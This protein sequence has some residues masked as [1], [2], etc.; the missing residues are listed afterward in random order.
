MRD[1]QVAIAGYGDSFADEENVKT[2]MELA[3]Q[4]AVAA[5]E[6]A[7]I[8]LADVDA[9]LT[10][11]PPLA[12]RAP[13]GPRRTPV[14]IQWNNVVASY[15]NI[16]T[17]HSTGVTTHGAGTIAMLKHAQAAIEADYVDTVLCVQSDAAPLFVDAFGDIPEG[18]A[19]PEFE[20]PYGP[21]MPALYAMWAS[22]HMTE[23]GTTHEQ[24]AK[25]SVESRKWGVRHPEAWANGRGE[26]TV[27]DVIDSRK[28]ASPLH[29]L[30]CAPWSG[31]AGGA[32]IVTEADR[33]EELHEKPVHI[34]G[35]GE[36]NT[37][38]KMI[39]RLSL[40]NRPPNEDGPNLTVTGAKEASRQAYEMA[41]MGPEDMDVVEP[42]TNFSHIG[43]L[44]LED[45]GF[46]EKGEGG[47]FVENGGIDFDGGLPFNTN[48][49][50]LS[51]GQ[52]AQG[53][54][55]MNI[56]GIRQIRRE[57]LGAQVE[58]AETALVH[59]IGGP[60]ACHA[61]AVLSRER[62]TYA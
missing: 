32:V 11:R 7:S 53:V 23:Y 35:V 6:D 49:G 13:G 38:E 60:T 3:V 48:G 1:T 46:C 33:A 51:F 36:Y 29:L 4:S 56:E 39:D 30:D 25:I 55:D 22:R 18:D 27:E 24:F 40:R 59:G 41:D 31:G 9:V 8:D 19:Q 45:F 5:A 52:T 28:I 57:A 17:K 50:W 14:G 21:V 43:L 20:L 42:C 58:D 54:M 12:N 2:P 47:E 16:P 26:I 34:R 37:H 15:L 62:G 44:L 61:V 10:G